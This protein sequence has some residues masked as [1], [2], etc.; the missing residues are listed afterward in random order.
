MTVAYDDMQYGVRERLDLYPH[1]LQVLLNGDNTLIKRY[2]PKG[3]IRVLKFGIQHRAT[4]GGTEVTIN[5]GKN[6]TTIGTVVASTD[7]APWTI[8][9]KPLINDFAAGDYFSFTGSGTVATG[10]V[11]CF[12]EYQRLDDDSKWNVFRRF[13]ES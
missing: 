6:G 2:Y 8:A 12:I 11:M 1:Q 13:A 7:T 10:S 9:S 3:P 4:Q 5:F